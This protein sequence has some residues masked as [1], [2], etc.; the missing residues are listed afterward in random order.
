MSET[1]AVR[2]FLLDQSVDARLV[3]FLRSLGHDVVRVGTDYPSGLPDPQVLAIAVAEQR[4]LVTD[5]R[6]LGEL[7]FRHRYP[8]RGVIYLRLGESAELSLKRA[9]LAHVLSNYSDKLDRFL[10]VGR[11]TVRVRDS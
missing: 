1:A 10:V 7:V 5:D 9:R 8:H 2:R 11:T 4:I 6:D 3:T